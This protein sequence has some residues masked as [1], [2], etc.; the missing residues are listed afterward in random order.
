V[1]YDAWQKPLVNVDKDRVGARKYLLLPPGYKHSVPAGFVPVHSQTYNGYALLHALSNA[2][3]EAISSLTLA[4]MLKLYPLAQAPNPPP[5]SSGLW[6]STT[7]QRAP[8]SASRR[9]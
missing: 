4:K 2:S 7:V 5:R 3:P 1:L 9:A 8:T 6:A